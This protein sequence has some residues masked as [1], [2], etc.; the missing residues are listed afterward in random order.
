[1]SA[2]VRKVT[3]GMVDIANIKLAVGILFPAFPYV[4][5]KYFLFGQSPNSFRCQAISVAVSTANGS[6]MDL[7]KKALE[8]P[9]RLV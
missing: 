2:D 3:V 7:T 6:M 1:M 5:Y 8:Y 9:F 4:R